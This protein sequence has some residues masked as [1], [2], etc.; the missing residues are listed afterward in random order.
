MLHSQ[1]FK[2]SKIRIICVC[3]YV[4]T[5]IQTNTHLA[6]ATTVMTSEHQLEWHSTDHT[7]TDTP[8]LY[9]H[10]RFHCK[11]LVLHQHLVY[12]SKEN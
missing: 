3:T 1:N 6:T 2:C 10:W 7:H 8:I 12:T 5:Y 9:P 4:R 11:P